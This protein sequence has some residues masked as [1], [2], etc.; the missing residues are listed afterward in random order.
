MREAFRVLDDLLQVGA[1]IRPPDAD[2]DIAFGNVGD[3]DVEALVL[4]NAAHVVEIARAGIGAVDQT[5]TVGHADDGE[6]SAH[7]ALVIKEVSVDALADIGIAADLGRAKPFQQ[8]DMIGAF[9]VVHGEVREVDDA[10]IFAQR[11]CSALETRQKWRLSHSF[12]R[13]GMRSPY[14][15][16]RCS[17]AA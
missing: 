13:T 3:G 11:G 1:G 4:G 10:A 17:L 12:S 9:D 2:G 7:H 6:I 16:S 14:F 8:L 15:S 5:A